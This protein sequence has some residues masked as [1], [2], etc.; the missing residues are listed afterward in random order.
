MLPRH[1]HKPAWQGLTLTLTLTPTP[2]LTLT[3]ILTLTLALTLALTLTLTGQV[4][5]LLIGDKLLVT[6]EVYQDYRKHSEKVMH[7]LTLSPP[8]IHLLSQQDHDCQFS[9]FPASCLMFDAFPQ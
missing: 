6:N 4:W 2:T 3:L 7:P 9:Q 8:R 5:P 1:P